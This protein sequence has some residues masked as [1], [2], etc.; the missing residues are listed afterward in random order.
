MRAVG[1][2]SVSDMHMFVKRCHVSFVSDLIQSDV[3]KFS[4]AFS[5][6]FSGSFAALVAMA[7]SDE[8]KRAYIALNVSADLQYV[9]QDNDVSLQNQYALSQHYKTL[10]VF[11]TFCDTRAE[12]RTALKDDF[13]IDQ[14]TDAPT[15][16][17]VAR[18]V[19]SWEVAREL[20]SKE[21][22]LRAESK[23]LGMPRI[24]QHSERQAMLKA[25][26]GVIGKLQE[27]ETPS[28]EYLAMKVEECENNEPTAASLDEVTSRYDTSTSA[29]QSSLDASGHV[30]VTKTKL[31]GKMPEDTEALRRVIKLEGIAWLAV[32]AKFRHKHW[33]HGLAIS[34]WTKYTDYILGDRVN[35]MKI[36]IDGQT[37]SV[38][39]PWSVILT[40]EHRLRKEA[41]K[42]VQTGEKTLS[43]ALADVIKNADLKESFFTTPIALGASQSGE[44]KWRR[45]GDRKGKGEFKGDYKGDGKGKKGKKGDR[46]GTGKDHH[47]NQLTSKTPDGR[48]ICY[49]FNSQGCR[50]RC[51]RV[52]VCR[53]AGC[54]GDHSAR[55]HNRYSGS[56]PP[57]KTE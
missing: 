40:Y 16:A 7:V 21:Q 18:I 3:R 24:L 49:A 55:E 27:A 57:K 28:N 15:R 1:S 35:N 22:E 29:L 26:E 5:F 52:H 56:E 9:W 14:A 23:V 12:V 47:G 36:Q 20:A 45:L 11:S 32:A 17:E 53:V 44:N 34:D 48:E 2:A 42:L 31:K 10:K 25:V 13:R 37:Q 41:F 43:E 38:R 54:Y 39:P 6:S 8:D 4:G 46:K 33:L 51:G 30:R 19:T 50:G